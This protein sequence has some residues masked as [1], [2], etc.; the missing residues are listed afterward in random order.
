[1]RLVAADGLRLTLD[2]DDGTQFTFDVEARQFSTT[3][4]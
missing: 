1:V 4:P 2:A 3:N